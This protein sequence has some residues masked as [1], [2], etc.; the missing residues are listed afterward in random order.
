MTTSYPLHILESDEVQTLF[1]NSFMHHKKNVKEYLSLMDNSLSFYDDEK[2]INLL[3]RI[4]ILCSIYNI[5]KGDAFEFIKNITSFHELQTYFQALKREIS[6]EKTKEKK[7]IKKGLLNRVIYGTT[8]PPLFQKHPRIYIKTDKIPTI[9]FLAR[10]IVDR[11]NLYV[12]K[13]N[14]IHFQE[15]KDQNKLSY[16]ITD[17][18]KQTKIGRFLQTHIKQIETLKSAINTFSKQY[19]DAFKKI[20]SD[21]YKSIKHINKKLNIFF[22]KNNLSKISINNSLFFEIKNNIFLTQDELFE[23]LQAIKEIYF[24]FAE[25]IHYIQIRTNKTSSL[26]N[27]SYADMIILST[28]PRDISRMS[29]YTS[30]S[31][32]MG[33]EDECNYDLPLQI[34]VGSIVAYLVN[35]NDPYKRL[36]RILL[37]PFVNQT[38][39]QHISA[40]LNYLSSP[41]WKNNLNE[42]ERLISFSYSFMESKNIWSDFIN[43]LKN[44]LAFK[45]EKPSDIEKIYLPDQQYGIIHQQFFIF[46]NQFLSQHINPNNLFGLFR[47]PASYYRDKL[48]QEYYFP[49]P[50]NS[51]NLKEYLISKNIPF[52]L[53]EKNNQTYTHVNSLFIN[54]MS[55]LNLNGV[56]AYHAKINATDLLNLDNRGIECTNL[57]ITNAEKLASL[58]QNIFVKKSLTLESTQMLTLPENIKVESLTVEAKKLKI[59]PSDIQ[60]SELTLIHSKVEKLP[61]LTLESLDAKH[62][63][64]TDLR[65]VNIKRY[66]D[67]SFTP[68]QHLSDNL[69]LQGL[70]LRHC[71]ELKKLP[72][73]LNVKW[74]DIGQTD[75]ENI[76]AL[77]YEY[78]LIANARKIK[79]FPKGTSFITL[80]AQG[81]SLEV[82]PDNLT[83]EKINI[84]KTKLQKLPNNLKIKQLLFLNETEISNFP[85]NL[86]AKEVYANKTKIKE[87]PRELKI[88]TLHMLDTPLETMH[89]SEHLKNIFLNKVPQFI[90]PNYS[91][92]RIV[93]VPEHEIKKAQKRYEVKYLTPIKITHQS[94]L[95]SNSSIEQFRT[96]E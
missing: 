17:K 5:N 61:P 41:E 28:N 79:E 66:L 23:Y 31:T 88:Q 80:E 63:K 96:I 58:S 84:S 15:N 64:L 83:A 12:P 55:G 11:L 81:S 22:K 85:E 50:N 49:N 7:I 95:N 39:Y 46:I 76:P 34:G 1:Q 60:I 20:F 53:V 3:T 43:N 4:S 36:G 14:M 44:E 21:N 33:Q 37:K 72:K 26:S 65:H 13:E 25:Q 35:S 29:E 57:T 93:G 38:G 67:L 70:F 77:K 74:L 54:N 51:D 78:L 16:L 75:I 52:H 68:I 8:L 47:T 94:N 91:V 27:V 18:K 19:F 40:R 6:K 59:I 86:V 69:N 9:S 90:H 2:T 87:L 24:N 45:I 82:L 30:W 73:N 71:T 10:E 32:C 62:S 48:Q 56:V 89:F 92:F 42:F